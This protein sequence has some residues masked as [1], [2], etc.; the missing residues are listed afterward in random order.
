[1]SALRQMGVQYCK[2]APKVS[3]QDG[4]SFRWGDGTNYCDGVFCVE[5]EKCQNLVHKK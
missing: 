2:I 5:Y 1:M 4:N 3:A